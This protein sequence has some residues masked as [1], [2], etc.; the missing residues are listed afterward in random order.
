MTRIAFGSCYHPSLESGI[1]NAIA[2]QHPDAFVFLGDNV[3]AEDE[4]DDPT[5][6][7]LDPIA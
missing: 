2:G 3:Y 6:M 7:S 1:F 4:S 5:L